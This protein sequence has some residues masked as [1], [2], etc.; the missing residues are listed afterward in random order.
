MRSAHAW[1]RSPCDL[2]P[3]LAILAAIVVLAADGGGYNTT[4]WSPAALF[5]LAV[6]GVQFAGGGAW[7]PSRTAWVAIAALAALCAWSYLSIHW[8]IVG[9]DAW[10][11]A[12]RTLLYLGVFLVMVRWARNRLGA[13]MWIA[14]LPLALAT[15]GG[16]TLVRALE[17]SAPQRLMVDS[18][19]ADPTG[20]PNATA[21]LFLLG[22]WPALALSAHR[23]LPPWFRGLLLASAGMLA[24]ISLIPQSRGAVYTLPVVLVLFIVLVPERL[25]AIGQILL[26]AG[27][28]LARLPQ[29]LG[30][31][32]T[33]ARGGDVHHAFVSA[34]ASIAVS[35]VVLAVVGTVLAYVDLRWRRSPQ[36]TRRLRVAA[37]VAIA[38]VTI[39]GSAA[40]LAIVGH[41]IQR[42]QSAW[43]SFKH[44]SEP[45]T[46]TTHFVGLG[47][48][49]YDFWRVAWDEF[50]VHPVVGVGA[51][52]YAVPYLAHRRSFEQPRYPHSLELRLLVG[53]GI[54][55]ALL[56][57]MFLGAESGRCFGARPIH[58]GAS[59]K[60]RAPRCSSPGSSTEASTGSGSS[61]RCRRRRSR[62]WQSRSPRA[63]RGRFASRLLVEPFG[64][65]PRSPVPR[66]LRGRRL[67]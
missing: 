13:S 66:S 31:Y 46:G 62:A 32:R 24:E 43:S 18:R 50:T 35:A 16:A 57:A 2:A 27:A 47:S 55:G 1:C 53:T 6:I 8:A 19:L 51:D 14:L 28:A 36:L 42:V 23:Q 37:T 54:V 5:V 25:R 7:S 65:L 41:P 20:Y 15:V 12:N 10:T 21:A 3:G 67:R 33:N 34:A 48:N 59:S 40:A 44:G 64:S 22:V 17:S 49:R 58:S 4:V 30:V 52:N 11:G 45:A 61:R 60:R 29:V 56:F 38:A 63:S 39:A 9:A 26:V